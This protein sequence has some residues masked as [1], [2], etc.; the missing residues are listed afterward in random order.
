LEIIKNL[1]FYKVL[2]LTR[3]THGLKGRQD[4]Q[5]LDVG[6]DRQARMEMQALK[7]YKARKAT[8]V[9]KMIQGLK[10]NRGNLDW[11]YSSVT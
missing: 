8:R 10:E 7:D 2:K 6:R 4:R 11:E 5:D 1:T 3:E 9:R